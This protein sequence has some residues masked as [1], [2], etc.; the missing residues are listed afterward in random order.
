M[1]ERSSRYG[2]I[3]RI[4][5]ALVWLL[6]AS[7]CITNKS[8]TYL[9]DSD[10]LPQYPKVPYTYYR[11]Q[12]NDQLVI[13]LLSL[14]EEATAIF[15]M[16]SSSSVATG[17]TYR[18]Y[19]DGTI[20][21][22]FVDNIPVAGLTIREASKVIES[23]LK[24]FVPDAMVKVA[25]A[26][27]NFYMLGLTGTKGAFPLY[28]EKL[29]IFQA[30]ALTGNVATNA[31]RKRVRLIRP[32]PQGGR[33]IVKEFDLRT[34]SIID[35]EYYYVQPNDVLYLGPIKGDFWKIENY[36]SAV[37]TL[38][39]SLNFLVTVLNLGLTFK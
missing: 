10:K 31:D 16:Q 14:N 4:G 39:T 11:I 24:D 9:Q 15:N 29:N 37:G 32:N 27:D 30:L 36:S 12:K 19:D 6:L 34:I 17:Y 38:S 25:L 35:S 22:P 2:A 33:P 20:D 5:I 28:K 21:I 23:R 3:V 1:Y 26:N 18:V 7:S 8:M 13:R